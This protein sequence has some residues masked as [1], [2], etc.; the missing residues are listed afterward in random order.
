M[1][2]GN[3]N[4]DYEIL[5]EWMRRMFLA[6]AVA[7]VVAGIKINHGCVASWQI[8]ISALIFAAAVG[9]GLCGMA[10]FEAARMRKSRN[11][12]TRARAWNRWKLA[13]I[14]YFASIAV[15]IAWR[16]IAKT[17]YELKSGYC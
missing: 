8:A 17:R 12:H 4:K 15:M 9:M 10:Q 7:I 2:G 16:L 13:T 6:A 5:Q 14:A 11:A 1:G 3:L